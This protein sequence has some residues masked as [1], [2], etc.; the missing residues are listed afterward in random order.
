MG[1]SRNMGYA[2]FSNLLGTLAILALLGGCTH[3][4]TNSNAP[5][6]AAQPMVGR[7]ITFAN[8]GH[9]LTNINVWSPDGEWIV[10][11]LRSDAGG[12]VFD[13]DRI[14]RVNVK[15]GQVQELY[16]APGHAKVGV[17]TYS[18][19]DDKVVFIQGPKNPTPDWSYAS[20]HRHGV[21]VDASKPGVAINLDARD[22]A[23]PFTPGALRGGT[24]VHVYSPDGKWVS[25]TYE[26]ALLP[27]AD[28]LSIPPGTDVN[29]R[30][31]GVSVPAGPVRVSS[32]NP[33]NLDGTFFSVLI[34]RTVRDPEPGSD[35]ISRAF[36]NSWVGTDG[37][38]KTDGTRQKR[39]IAFQASVRTATGKTISE[40]F[41]IDLPSKVSDMTKPGNGPLAGTS[42]RMPAPP[43]GVVQR[44][45]TFTSTRKYPGIQGPRH[46][47]NSSPDGSQ[48]ALLMRDD[49]GVVQIWTISPN[50]GTPVQV[51]HDPWSVASA[52]TWNHRGGWIAYVADNSIFEVNIATGK[53]RR[54]T[55]RCADVE[56]PLPLA[57]VYSPDGRLIAYERRVRSESKIHNQIFVV[58]SELGEK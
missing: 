53:S 9:I 57:C 47:L 20:N 54:L 58:S 37:Y 44:R 33:H 3:M 40:A 28:A 15:T 13:S 36:S 39:A 8:V 27:D 11:D 22:L 35:Q 10:F 55:P 16:K 45:L 6:H 41:I 42:T 19:I 2:R 5:I 38:I 23:P 24:H 26:D 43:A 49:W 4:D 17:V 31:I 51:T 1:T 56:A 34:T 18:P 32:D 14:E 21:I 48:I 46:W 7:Q 30:N 52:F 29:A 50:G 12:S 25:F